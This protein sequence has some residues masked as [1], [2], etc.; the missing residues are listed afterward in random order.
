MLARLLEDPSMVE[1]LYARDPVK[2]MCHWL[3]VYEPRNAGKTDLPTKMPF[4]LF[5]RQETLIHFFHACVVE[6]GN[7]L[8]EKSR[9]MGA[10]WCGVGYS[11][12]MWRFV[13][14]SAIG[15]GSATSDKLD[16]L[17]DPGSIFEKIRLAIRDLPPVFLPK[18]FRD[19][20]LMHKRVIN[21]DNGNSI[22]GDIGDNIGRGGR[23]RLYFVDEA[24]YL[25]H[26]AAVEAAL[27]ENTRVRID[28]SS[29]SAPGT[30]FHRSREA[31]AEWSPGRPIA[32][33]RANVFIMDWSD[34]PEKNRD[35]ADT[36]KAQFE[37]KGLGHVYAREIERN[38]AATIEGS[39]IKPEWIDAALDAHK[40]LGLEKQ[41]ADGPKYAGL[42]VGDGGLD[43]NALSVREHRILRRLKQWKV[44]D[45]A[46]TARNA[47][48][49]CNDFLPLELN[50]DAISIGSGIKSETN[51]LRDE[52][53]LP[54]GLIVIPWNAG[55]AV[56]NPHEHIIP[57]DTNTPKNKDHF[58]N[59]KAQA[60][61]NMRQAFYY[62][63]LVVTQGV[64]V[65][66][67]QINQ[68]VSIDTEA[69]NDLTLIHKFR[70]ELSQAIPALTGK[71]KT[72]VDKAPDGVASPNMAD[73]CVMCFFPMPL[74]GMDKIGRAHV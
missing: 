47:V 41:F 22:T 39:I 26:A 58:A 59:L 33:D 60:W 4:L 24:A 68:L 32:K 11:V 8:V 14:G 25:E 37:S 12:W 21:A 64:A 67:F 31:G 18:K 13:P 23:T 42:D 50:Y 1:N 30:V 35:W 73:S 2:F 54:P 9:D 51:R 49:E 20:D 53:L 48:K 52:G 55:A 29:V 46:I 74:T 3:N 62:T 44:R 10:T 63:W 43:S 61:W 65:T 15:W 56:L 38:Y 34:H 6:E 71:M 7:G 40:K 28:I 45:T 66:S 69:I 16:R 36:R 17:G 27:S 70:D 57:N 19:D 5:K 72:G